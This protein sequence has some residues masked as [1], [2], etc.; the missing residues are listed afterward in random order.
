M[1]LMK[2]CV[3][4]QELAYVM[5]YIHSASGRLGGQK[6]TRITKMTKM[7]RF[8]VV[9]LFEAVHYQEKATHDCRVLMV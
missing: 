1:V 7:A 5:L 9:F 3:R 2:K 4:E 8:T 6:G